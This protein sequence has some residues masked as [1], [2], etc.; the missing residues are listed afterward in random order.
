MIDHD[1]PLTLQVKMPFVNTI[2]PQSKKF[3]TGVS[4][5]VMP[6]LKL[7]VLHNKLV[8]SLLL[9]LLQLPFCTFHYLYSTANYV[10][11]NLKMGEASE[12]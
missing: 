5:H 6:H 11:F 8:L 10:Q 9:L 3:D 7:R 1:G 4:F 12:C 2:N